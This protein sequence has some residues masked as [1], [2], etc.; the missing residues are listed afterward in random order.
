M[1]RRTIILASLIGGGILTLIGD[2]I[3]PGYFLVQIS[4]TLFTLAGA[5]LFESVLAEELLLSHI[6]DS[7]TR[8]SLNKA[9]G[10][11]T[12]VI[13]FVFVI[14]IWI[15]D[16]QS[17]IVALGIIGAG[18][19]IGL[20]DVVRNFVGGIV[21]LS[22]N[23]YE[24]GDRIE[25]ADELGDVMDIGLLNTTVMELRGWV[26]GD[27]PTG[28]IT[29]IPNGK[30]ITGPVHN[31]T[32]D[33]SFLWDE[34][35]IPVTYDSNWKLAKD[36]ILEIVRSETAATVVE[37]RAEIESI[38]VKYYL[39]K[40]VVEPAVYISPTD[41]SIAIHVRYVTEVTDRREF[42]TRL[43][44]M[45]LAK[46]QETPGIRIFSSASSDTADL[47]TKKTA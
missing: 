47:T 38:G 36:T 32:K 33:H 42:R 1:F 4:L 17:L 16:T 6:T 15:P 24:V 2:A 21:I 28:R 46:I 7:K 37:A 5:Y 26:N 45:I 18:L 9:I 39:P 27:Q 40:N 3:F 35:M 41:A 13:A 22:S 19:A 20:Q 11:F 8:Y 43:V 34:I 12:A 29:A 25:L 23:I 31:Y 30:V 10:I 44:E 14:R